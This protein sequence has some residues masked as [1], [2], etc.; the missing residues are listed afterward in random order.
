MKTIS[1]TPIARAYLERELIRRSERNSSYS[2]RSFAKNLGMSATTLSLFLSGKRAVSKQVYILIRERLLLESNE[3]KLLNKEFE[4]L[5][6]KKNFALVKAQLDYKMEQIDLDTFAVISDW[7]HYAIL[8]YLEIPN[9][10]LGGEKISKVFGISIHQANTAI[11][12]LARLGLIKEK[13]GKR[14]QSVEPIKIENKEQKSAI[15]KFH[16]QM[17]EK[18]IHY[19][20]NGEF[21]QR[22]ISSVTFAMNKELVPYAIE[23]IRD[24]RRELMKDLENRSTPGDVYQLNVQL[25]PLTNKIQE[26]ES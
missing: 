15:R 17:L 10:S 11:E 22:D 6:Q 7:Y 2:L 20:E 26:N 21:S 4:L 25:F 18:A 1:T 3:L 5:K 23:R 14:R 24:F 19:L 12:R 8:S 16:K 13:N 9:T